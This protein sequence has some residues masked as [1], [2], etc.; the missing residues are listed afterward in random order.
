M[1][2]FTRNVTCLWANGARHRLEPGRLGRCRA[3]I[4][5]SA[6]AYL[7]HLRLTRQFPTTIDL[8]FRT[9]QY[10][11]SLCR[12]IYADF[13]NRSHGDRQIVHRVHG[14]GRMV[15]QRINLFRFHDFHQHYFQSV[16]FPLILMDGFSRFYTRTQLT[17]AGNKQQSST[18]M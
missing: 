5:P 6:L 8:L 16:I 10:R 18:A 7:P 17:A 13:N 4:F 3:C 2:Y 15:M 14:Y 1:K 11:N 12:Q 9:K